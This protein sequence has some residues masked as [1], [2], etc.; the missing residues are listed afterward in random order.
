M[1]KR[2]QSWDN[3][4]IPNSLMVLRPAGNHYVVNR[5]NRT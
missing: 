3:G 4:T 5:D 1:S 2:S